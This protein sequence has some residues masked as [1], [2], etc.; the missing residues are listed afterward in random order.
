MKRA[1]VFLDHDMTIRHFVKSGA[2]ADLERR[3]EVTYVVN[4][5][6]HPTGQWI[7]TDP[8]SLGLER[9]IVLRIPRKRMG[10]WYKLYA[11]S[12]L[13]NQRGTRNY[14]GRKLRMAEIDG[15][16][17][18]RR[19]EAFSLPGIFPL[20]RR[21]YLSR[22]GE[23]APL[24]A[25]L[26]EH[27]PDICIYPSML[28]GYFMNE[29]MLLCPRLA[30]PFVVLMNSWDNPSQKA[31][32]TGVPDRLVVWGE[33]TRRHA[34]EYM[35]MPD[36]RIEVFGAAQFQ[37]YRKPVTESRAE[38]CAMFGLPADD[39]PVVLYAGVSKSIDETRHLRLLDAAIEN[40]RTPPCRILYRPHPWR[41][42]LIEGEEHFFD[43]GLRHVVMD[44]HMEPYYRRVAANPSGAF[45]MADYEV[46][47]RLLHLVAGSISTLSTI[48]LETVLLGKPTIS[49]M[50]KA[51]MESKYGRS[52]AI[53]LK[54]AHFNDLWASPGV[55]ICDDD[56]KL[57]EAVATLVRQSDDPELRRAIAERGR[58]FAVLDGPTYSER[59][60][61]LADRLA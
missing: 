49:F 36:D 31:V 53:S 17:R 26:E 52:A 41:G 22:M 58:D 6:P 56:A 50:P 14:A 10:D 23:W 47:A 25:L 54:L 43:A 34:I 8:E 29:L 33:H 21:R 55:T 11:V 48:Q 27:R 18:M 16:W 5:D 4:V 7:N 30:I 32:V 61:E 28:T 35:R 12:V 59:L 20:Y 60:A 39:L 40:G 13:A 2:F 19:Y 37:V 42:S 9:L 51:D 3:F 15:T 44:P 24:R 46:T 38:L 1:F 57:P 45:E